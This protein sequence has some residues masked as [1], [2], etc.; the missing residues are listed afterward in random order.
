MQY[1]NHVGAEVSGRYTSLDVY[2]RSNRKEVDGDE[3]D[4][5]DEHSDSEGEDESDGDILSH[6]LA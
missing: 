6:A 3:S 5:G 4:R 1:L 2:T